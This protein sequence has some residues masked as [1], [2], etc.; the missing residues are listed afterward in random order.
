MAFL[1]Q[2]GLFD[3]WQA[4]AILFVPRVMHF[5]QYFVIWWVGG[6]SK[7]GPGPNGPGPKWG[8]AQIGPGPKWAWAQMGT[9][10]NGPGP[11]MG[12]GPIWARAQNGSGPKMDPGPN[13]T[14]INFTPYL[15]GISRTGPP[16]KAPV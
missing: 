16:K 11:K 2:Y 3:P 15:L 13:K 14:N 4:M 6:W 10:P 12:P 1:T 9:D 8:R 7:L 5:M